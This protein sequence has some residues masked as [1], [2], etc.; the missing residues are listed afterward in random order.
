MFSR[1]TLLALVLGLLALVGGWS[2]RPLLFDSTSTPAEANAGLEA[3]NAMLK[4]FDE[5]PL[6]YLGDEYEGLPLVYCEHR[7]TSGT[8]YGIPPTDQVFFIYGRC[9]P[10]GDDAPS[11]APPLQV[12]ILPGC[13]PI[14][15]RALDSERVTVRG[16]GVSMLG[17]AAFAAAPGFHVQ[18][19]A[20]QG[21]ASTNREAALRA[22]ESLRGAN[23][24]A[25]AI[26][27]KSSLVAPGASQELNA[28][29]FS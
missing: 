11:C 20:A 21:D 23:A 26:L 7:R 16:V 18:I 10:T 5:Y 22:L 14:P 4:T 12:H 2:L 9:T 15:V 8:S 1:N 3:C 27:S 24:K 6:V 25:S 28:S 29:C 13:S 19:S 17:D